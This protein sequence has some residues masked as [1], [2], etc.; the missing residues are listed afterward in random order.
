M[1][2]ALV[3]TSLLPL[4]LFTIGSD[5]FAA[6][7]RGAIFPTA[8]INFCTPQKA[9]LAIGLT[10]TGWFDY[11]GVDSGWFFTLEPGLSGGSVNAGFRTGMNLFLLPMFRFDGMVSLMH[12]W[13]NPW[14][15]LEDDQTYL[16]IRAATW[17]PLVNVSLGLFRHVGGGDDDHNWLVTAGVG[18]G[19]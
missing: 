7:G 4:L 15:G 13:N 6:D 9:S 10:N 14:G 3:F 5:M 8:S 16:G 1:K 2:L 18:V 17:V 11:F 19:L 12:T